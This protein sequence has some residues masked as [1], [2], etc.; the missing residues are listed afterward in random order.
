MKKMTNQPNWQPLLLSEMETVNHIADSIHTSLPERPEVFSEKVS[1]F[2]SGCRKLVK[3]NKMVGYGISHPWML[4]S[5][6]PLDDF[7]VKLP[8]N[9]ECLYIHDVVVMPE[10]RGHGAA[11]GYVDHI[12]GVAAQMGIGS[13][14]LVSVYGTDVLWG[15]FGFKAVQ[16]AELSRKLE[17]YGA[18]AKYMTCN[19]QMV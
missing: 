15:R 7:L 8:H 5:I 2:P 10:A 11:A 12:K 4:D 14:A 16:N 17:S 19:L 13:L 6:P 3:G 9:P 18:T 1:L